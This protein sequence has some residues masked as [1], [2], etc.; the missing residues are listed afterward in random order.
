VPDVAAAGQI[1][2]VSTSAEK[3]FNRFAPGPLTV[4]LPRITGRVGDIAS[5][6]LNSIGV[7]IP[8]HPVAQALLR[9]AG[10]PVAAPSANI[11]GRLSATS[12][13]MVKN[14][15]LGRVDAII[16]GGDCDFGLESTVI[17]M[18]D[19]ARPRLLRSGAVSVR[20][21]EQCLGISV[22]IGDNL[23]PGEVIRSP[24]Q[25]YAHY[26]PIV[27]L[28]LVRAGDMDWEA[29]MRAYG[30]VRLG[31][32]A[33]RDEQGTIHNNKW[34]IV[35]FDSLRDYAQGLY[36]QMW[37]LGQAC[38][39]LIAVLPVNGDIGLALNNR[40]IKAANGNFFN[41]LKS[42]NLNEYCED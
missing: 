16:D 20:D 14:G 40:L 1:A 3:L 4:V 23:C 27:P 35:Y 5:A 19:E 33:L 39:R 9:A 28:E 7:R 18:L 37:R 38:D 10:V 26:Q 30:D 41:N 17:S 24:G 12:F 15:L 31:I 21:L 29:L 13:E 34:E 42:N 2:H 8:A 22:E 11:S 6:G 25:K 32:L 36:R